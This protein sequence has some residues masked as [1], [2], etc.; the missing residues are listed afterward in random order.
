MIVILFFFFKQK[1]AYEMRISDWSSDVCSSDLGASEHHLASR[2]GVHRPHHRAPRGALL[3]VGARVGGL[4]ARRG[5]RQ[6][7]RACRARD[8]P[9]ER[10]RG[11]RL[12][13]LDRAAVRDR[14]RPRAGVARSE[15]PASELPSLMRISSAVFSFNIN[16]YILTK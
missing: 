9:R 7:P 15:E 1:T 16:N 10:R 6:G 14:R 3:G 11:A 4:C 8:D 13:I 12:S 2:A 5:E